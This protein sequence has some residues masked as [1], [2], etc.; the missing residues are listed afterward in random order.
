LKNDR[1]KESVEVFK[2]VNSMMPNIAVLQYHLGYAYFGVNN[3]AEAEKILKLA[4]TNGDK[5]KTEFL[6]KSKVNALLEELK[7]KAPVAQTPAI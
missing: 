2:Q 5:Q 1:I 7:A 6:E 3:Y 4:L